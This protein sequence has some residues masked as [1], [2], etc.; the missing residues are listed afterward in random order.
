[1]NEFNGI[2]L[3]VYFLAGMVLIALCGYVLEEA[4]RYFH[5]REQKR[6]Q[7][8]AWRQYEH[9]LHGAAHK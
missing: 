1:M 6:L 3:G 5:K 7:K 2:S 8:Q 9:W 4:A